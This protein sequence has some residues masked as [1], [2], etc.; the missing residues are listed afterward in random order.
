MK[1]NVVRRFLAFF[2]LYLVV[3]LSIIVVQFARRTGFTLTV[4]SIAVSGRYATSDAASGPG[5]RALSGSL[6]VF[7][8]GMEFRLADDEGFSNV[9]TDGTVKPLHPVSMETSKGELSVLLSDGGSLRF[10]TSF[11][12]GAESLRVSA[13]PARSV[14]EIRLPF[15]PLRSSRVAETGE[16]EG[17]VVSAG[18]TYS[19]T[20]ANIDA[21]KRV[22]ALKA[23]SPSFAYGKVV[24]KKGFSPE[25][26]TSAQAADKAAYDRALQRWRDAAYAGWERSMAG[27]PVED[28]VVAYVAESARR[29]TYRSAVATTPKSFLDGGGRGYRS[30]AYF[31]QLDVGLRSLAAAERETLGKLSRLANERDLSLFVETDLI[32][33]LSVRASRTFSD[34][35]ATFARS[36]DPSVITPE[37]AVGFLECWADWKSYRSDAA[38]PFDRLVDQA[39]FVLGENLR[40]AADGSVLPV[41]ADRA[42][43]AF[44]LRAGRALI[45]S[46]ELSGDR[47]WV[48]LGRTIVL[49]VIALADQAGILP[50]QLAL[51][52]GAASP[53]A[54]GDARLPSS[55]VNRYLAGEAFL[56][57]AIPLDFGGGSVFWTWTAASSVTVVQTESSIEISVSFPVG[58]THY[59]LVRGV[60][61]FRKIQ[62][63][64]IDF[65][66]DPRFE[67]YDSSGW[68]YSA[69]EQTLLLKMKHKSATERVGIFY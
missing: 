61:P 59:M 44:A 55:A 30:S 60:K 21:T 6:S 64:G 36:V 7:F 10:Q 40:R 2:S 22:V 34:S 15:R 46:A 16:G 17:T 48:D 1:G 52:P 65:R 23:R 3:L 9:G 24:P 47:P 31:G 13:S 50:A 49:S 20:Q 37:L 41:E 56:P 57:R 58:E 63:Y 18:E 33:Y 29:G 4:G 25:D 67:R 54:S 26:F 12:A 39:H 69:S 62:L 45:R 5:V 35:V 66:T 43:T 38:N 42:D 27:S 14:V 32:A 8:G 53:A 28:A 11:T 68:A 19:F 51:A